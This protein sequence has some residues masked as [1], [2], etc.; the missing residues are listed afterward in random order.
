MRVILSFVYYFL[1]WLRW[2]ISMLLKLVSGILMLCLILCICLYFAFPLQQ[3]TLL[4]MIWI[5]F[6]G[7]FGTFLLRKG[8]EVMLYKMN[9]YLL[10]RM[11]RGYMPR[12]R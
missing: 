1:S 10:S 7:S 2:P 4:R 9:I 11:Q 8:Y 3:D 6:G 5:S 12:Y